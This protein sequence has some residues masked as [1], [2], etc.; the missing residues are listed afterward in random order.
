MA[1]KLIKCTCSNKYQDEKYGKGVRVANFG[2]KDK[3][4]RC[5]VCLKEHKA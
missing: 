3:I 2:D 4:W 1:T 5:I